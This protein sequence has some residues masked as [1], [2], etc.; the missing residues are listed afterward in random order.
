MDAL[1]VHTTT[2]NI[3][4]TQDSDVLIL[5]VKPQMAKDVCQELGLLGL[6]SAFFL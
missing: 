4:A 5:A 6:S 2:S 3:E 1:G